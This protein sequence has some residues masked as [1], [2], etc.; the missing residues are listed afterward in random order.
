[1]AAGIVPSAT[2]LG[3]D[4]SV[5]LTNLVTFGELLWNISAPPG[6]REDSEG[7]WRQGP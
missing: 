4:P 5:P 3:L 7:Q 1:M 6:A 2:V